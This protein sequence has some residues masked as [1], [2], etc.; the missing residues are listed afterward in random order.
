MLTIRPL[1]SGLPGAEESGAHIQE[2]IVEIQRD[3][4]M[5]AEELLR[6]TTHPADPPPITR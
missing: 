2:L 6:S 4:K 3:V 1:S 5:L